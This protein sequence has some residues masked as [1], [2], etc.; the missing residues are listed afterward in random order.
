MSNP[1]LSSA[2]LDAAPSNPLTPGIAPGVPSAG[3]DAALP[4]PNADTL[5]PLTPELQSKIIALSQEL[6]PG[7]VSI[8]TEFDPEFPDDQWH[9]VEVEAYGE[10]REIL[11]R[12]LLWHDKVWELLGKDIGLQFRLSV[13]PK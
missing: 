2:P 8:Q 10:F 1:P 9:A 12:E 13:V 3:Q 5:V 11:D 6:F 7:P 4:P